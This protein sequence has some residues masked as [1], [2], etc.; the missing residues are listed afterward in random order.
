MFQEQ[1]Q[2][3]RLSVE[4]EK[5]VGLVQRRLPEALRP[6]ALQVPVVYYDRPS[7]EIL[8]S[9][10]DEDILGM[11]VGEPHASEAGSG[12][13]PCHILLFLENLL[14]EA[15]GDLATFREEVRITYLH[16]L[17]HYLGW[18]E[19]ALEVRGLA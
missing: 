3:A 5:V 9:E 15:E 11:F 1:N 17:G 4:A 10:F 2:P 7:P 8:G 16:E 6:L 13:V 12:N 14:D 19:D 18:D